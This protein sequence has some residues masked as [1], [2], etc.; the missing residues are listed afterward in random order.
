MCSWNKD[1]FNPASGKH[2]FQVHPTCEYFTLLLFFPHYLLFSLIKMLPTNKT[3]RTQKKQPTKQ[4]NKPQ[5]KHQVGG[6]GGIK[7]SNR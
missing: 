6:S 5:K 7:E 2:L 3:K 1:P 4:R